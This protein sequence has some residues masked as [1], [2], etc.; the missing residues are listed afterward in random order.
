VSFWA[1]RLT[2]SPGFPVELVG[3]GELHAAFLTES[4]TPEPV[5]TLV[6]EI[7]VIPSRLKTLGEFRYPG[8][9]AYYASRLL[10]SWLVAV[11]GTHGNA[12]PALGATARKHRCSRFGLHARQKAMCLRPMAAV[13][14]E[15]AL[16]HNTA[17]LISLKFLPEGKL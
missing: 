4:R 15:C 11:A 7:R 3:V 2:R 14:L 6:Q 8:Y 9:G 10:V 13:W 16:G 5:W 1:R 17:L 12:L